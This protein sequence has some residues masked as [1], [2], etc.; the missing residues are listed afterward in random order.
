M[1]SV[2][3]WEYDSE[4]GWT[5]VLAKVEADLGHIKTLNEY[6]AAYVFYFGWYYGLKCV[7]PKIH[8][9]A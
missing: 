9:Q 5:A 7:L 4:G 6:V 2:F 1:I 8:C 3:H